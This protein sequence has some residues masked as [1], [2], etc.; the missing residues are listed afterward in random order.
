MHGHRRADL[1]RSR[2]IEVDHTRHLVTGDQWLA[3]GEDARRA[4]GVV[5]QVGPADSG[6]LHPYPH[7]AGSRLGAGNLLGPHVV[8]GMDPHRLHAVSFSIDRGAD[9]AHPRSSSQLTD[10]VLFRGVES[11][12]R[13]RN[14]EATSVPAATRMLRARSVTLKLTNCNAMPA[15]TTGSERPT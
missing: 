14:G 15:P 13:S 3:N 8:L 4:V 10:L 7:L 9:D 2:R 1:V 5:M 12:T 11:G 6:E